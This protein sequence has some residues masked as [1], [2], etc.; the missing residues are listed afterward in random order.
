MNQQQLIESGKL[1]LYVA[2][3]LCGQEARTV[4]DMISNSP[5][6]QEEV[7]AIEDA[8]LAA[9]SEGHL[10]P[11]SGVKAKILSQ[12]NQP[13]LLK[14]D[15]SDTKN[16]TKKPEAKIIKMNTAM[17][18]VAAA[19]VLLLVVLGAAYYK[20]SAKINAQQALIDNLSKQYNVQLA[21]VKGDSAR[22]SKLADQ[23]A[24]INHHFTKKIVLSGGASDPDSRAIVYW[25]TFNGRVIVNPNNLPKAPAGNEYQVWAIK[26]GKPV[27]AGIFDVTDDSIKLREVKN[28]SSA[29]A[30]AI[31][32]E[33]KGVT[34]GPTSSNTLVKGNI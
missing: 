22:L 19:S 11:G 10:M 25:N 16:D 18:W 3:A 13:L 12:T 30:F 34:T 15:F 20:Q 29:Q 28:I 17:Q 8:M 7:R 9:L 6:L 26:D 24:L 5:V 32:L 1:E 4:A 31:I 21:A 2:G 23:L 33:P 14:R 27:N